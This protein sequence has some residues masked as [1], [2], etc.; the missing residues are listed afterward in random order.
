MV[1]KRLS[2]NIY[3]DLY[4][5]NSLWKKYN[6]VINTATLHEIVDFTINKVGFNTRA[7][8]VELSIMLIDNGAIKKYNLQYRNKDKPT[9]VLSFPTEELIAE[10]YD[11][12]KNLEYIHLGDALFAIETIIRE[13]EEQNKGFKDHF[14]HL[15]VHALLH[16][17]GFNHTDE[18]EAIKMEQF[19]IEILK[20]FNINSPYE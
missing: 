1:N 20:N 9:N 13:A 12:I 6:A 18:K 8:K 5:K 14:T 19:E 3:I 2:D 7:T 17:L 4:T 16:L 11:N 10:Q 15:L